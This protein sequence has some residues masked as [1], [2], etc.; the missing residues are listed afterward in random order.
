[1]SSPIVTVIITSYNHEKYLRECL[2]SALS[3]DFADCEFIVIDDNSKDSTHEILKEYASK[4]QIVMNTENHGTYGV[5]NQGLEMAKGKYC[6]ILNSDDVWL[7]EKIKKQVEL[8]ETEDKMTFCHTYG[9]FIDASGKEVDGKPMGFAFPKTPTGNALAIFVTN[10]SAI[11]SAVMMRTGTA[12]KI[13][14]FDA[15]F[16]NLGDWD[17]WLKMSEEGG[18][19]FVDEELT[20]YRIHG[21]NTIYKTETTRAEDMRIRKKLFER[22]H[23]LMQKAHNKQHMRIA[24]AHNIACLGSLY[25]VSGEAR[26][27][28]K[29]YAQSLKYYPWRVKTMLR[30]FL[31]FAPLSV[32]KRT[33]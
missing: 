7:P 11:A 3:Q 23:E 26:M 15:S 30:F 32:R 21:E 1:M 12:R 17:M 5:L 29:M 22:R 13:G 25:S 20:L 2:D 27:A 33:L 10:N 8:L 14:G 18:V 24:M 28:R 19:G 6:A 4:M 16:K 9:R 31:T